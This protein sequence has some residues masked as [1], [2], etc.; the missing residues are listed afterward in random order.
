MYKRYINI[1]IIILEFKVNTPNQLQAREK[2]SDI[3]IV[4]EVKPSLRTS[5]KFKKVGAI[6]QKEPIK[7]HVIDARMS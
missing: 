1:T 7:L 5:F 4:F 2:A 3:I 6:F